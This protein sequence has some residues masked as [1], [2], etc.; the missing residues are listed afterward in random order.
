MTNAQR[1]KVN[2]MKVLL[3]GAFGHLGEDILKE[4]VKNN[5]EVIAC[6]LNERE[7]EGTKGKYTFIKIDATKPETL[8]GICDGCEVVITTM[9]LTGASKT[10]SAYDIDYQG[11]LNLLNEA[12]KAHVKYFNYV[13]VIKADGAPSVPM[14]DAKAKFELELKKSGI[15]YVIYRPT[16]YFY[17]IAKVFK[18]MIEKGTVSLLGDGSCKANVID[19]AD[20]AEFIVKHMIDNNQTYNIGGKETYTYKE[21]AQLCAESAGKEIKIKSAPSWLF[22]VLAFINKVNKSGREGVIRFGKWTLTNDLVG[23]TV[24]GDASFKEYLKEYF[25]GK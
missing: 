8:N 15:Q 5:H 13:S 10:I 2:S 11:N 25:G 20:F 6:D 17:D 24:Y 1:R 16:G 18:P 14:L 9:G 12:V 22:D 4:L 19:T 21:I 7:I 23:D 3:A